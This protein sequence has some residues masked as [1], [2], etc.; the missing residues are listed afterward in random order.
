MDPHYC[1]TFT[2]KIINRLQNKYRVKF[3]CTWCLAEL[4][5]KV[6]FI[7]DTFRCDAVYLEHFLLNPEKKKS[8]STMK[9]TRTD[10]LEFTKPSRPSEEVP[11]EPF[12]TSL[13]GWTIFIRLRTAGFFKNHVQAHTH[14]TVLKGKISR[15]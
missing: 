5:N 1:F 12:K 2:Y 15:P 9:N 14:G 3:W 4:L 6:L 13:D 10:L 7:C 11:S 8:L